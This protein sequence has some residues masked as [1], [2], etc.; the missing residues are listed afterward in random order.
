MRSTGVLVAALTLSA[1][2]ATSLPVDRYYRIGAAT[3]HPAAPHSQSILVEPFEAR[4]VYAERALLFQ[5]AGSGSAMRQYGHQFWI[6]PPAA[7]LDAALAAALRGAFGE[8]NVH[9]RVSRERPD[10]QV[11]PRLRKLEQVIEDGQARAAYAVDF[12][13]T[14]RDGRPRFVLSFDESEPAATAG[15]D[16]YVAALDVLVARAN[17][18]LVER[19]ATAFAR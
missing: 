8:A 4:G 19:L 18:R 2:A 11:Q 14:D 7:M 15:P 12:T 10:F 3:R 5:E 17:A 6:E 9:A 13:V 1:C 16:T